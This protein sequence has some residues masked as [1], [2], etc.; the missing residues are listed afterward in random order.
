LAIATAAAVCKQDDVEEG[1][2]EKNTWH[3]LQLISWGFA[4]Q[5]RK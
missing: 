5:V 1:S 3:G 4:R 2:I